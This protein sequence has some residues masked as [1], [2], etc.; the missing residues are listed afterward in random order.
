LL[1][2]DRP[3]PLLVIEVVSNSDTDK[4][5]R[6]RDYEEKRSE[7]AARGIPEYGI[8]NPIASAV[9]IL[10]LDGTKYREQRFE[11]DRQIVSP[12]FPNLNLTTDRM[13]K[14]GK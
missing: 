1:R 10:T 6:D 4:K 3:A 12:G 8:I 14:A 2:F 5:S 11:E 13:L 7:Y 9:L